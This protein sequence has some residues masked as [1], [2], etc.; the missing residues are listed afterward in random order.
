MKDG[1]VNSRGR[2]ASGALGGLAAR[3]R[4]AR[5]RGDPAGQ[6]A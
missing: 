4:G 3:G 1:T 5:V 2:Q 6:T